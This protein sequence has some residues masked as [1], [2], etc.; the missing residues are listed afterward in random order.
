MKLFTISVAEPQPGTGAM[1]ERRDRRWP[2]SELKKRRAVQPVSHMANELRDLLLRTVMWAHEQLCS[3]V[4]GVGCC[5][6]GDGTLSRD[7]NESH[8]IMHQDAR[9]A[10]Q[11]DADDASGRRAAMVWQSQKLMS[12]RVAAILWR[13]EEVTGYSVETPRASCTCGDNA[14][15]AVRLPPQVVPSVRLPV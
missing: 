2:R 13:H 10:Q 14:A 6:D 4:G 9:T 8:V 12:Y 7:A 11:S 5:G 15:R 3:W 1:H